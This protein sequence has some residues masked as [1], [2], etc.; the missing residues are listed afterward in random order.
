M[1]RF[2]VAAYT[3]ILLFIFSGCGNVSGPGTDSGSEKLINATETEQ[4][5]YSDSLR[6]YEV[7]PE[8]LSVLISGLSENCTLYLAKMNPTASVIAGDYTRYVSSVSGLADTVSAS[9]S[10]GRAVSD[11]GEIPAEVCSGGRIRNFVPPRTFGGKKETFA[12]EAGMSGARTITLGSTSSAAVD[13]T[14]G[15]AKSV[16]IDTDSKISSFARKR[17]T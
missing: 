3:F 6:V 16:Y 17:A 2:Q 11:S 1:K 13:Y 4:W 8:I 5:P 9:V 15:A 12:A 10:S 7:K 14:V